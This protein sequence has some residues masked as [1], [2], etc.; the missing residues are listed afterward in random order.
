MREKK[1]RKE[2]TKPGILDWKKKRNLAGF[3]LSKKKEVKTIVI[4][5]YH[6][7]SQDV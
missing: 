4:E 2:K 6:Y 3:I 7:I 5:K 1:K